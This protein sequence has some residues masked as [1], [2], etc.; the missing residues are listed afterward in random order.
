MKGI[1]YLLL[2]ISI[3]ARRERL[4]RPGAAALNGYVPLTQRLFILGCQKPDGTQGW[5]CELDEAEL[6]NQL[7]PYP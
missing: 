6:I 4:M 7:N 3:V 1:R 5:L 2:L